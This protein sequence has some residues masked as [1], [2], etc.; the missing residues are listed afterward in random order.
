MGQKSSVA[1]WAAGRGIS[2]DWRRSRAPPI[3]I[4][5]SCG[6]AWRRH[7]GSAGSLYP[8]IQCPPSASVIGVPAGGGAQFRG[9]VVDASAI[10][11]CVEFA[12][13]VGHRTPGVL[14]RRG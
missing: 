7:R 2:E 14:C 13:V 9:T 10:E 1:A 3:P 11:Y 6:A 12:V 5:I 8:R 4:Q